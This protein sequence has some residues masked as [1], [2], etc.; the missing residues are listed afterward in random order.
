MEL[1]R[2]QSNPITLK[3][4]IH[5]IV[6]DRFFNQGRTTEQID[7]ML[8]V[9]LPGVQVR[10]II[11]SLVEEGLLAWYGRCVRPIPAYCY[12]QWPQ[13]KRDQLMLDRRRILVAS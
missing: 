11:W 8:S 9:D 10:E 13:F 7:I 1:W 12:H 6:C 5:Q 3:R 2:L 4:E